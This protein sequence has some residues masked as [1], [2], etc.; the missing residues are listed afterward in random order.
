MGG[1]AGQLRD[2]GGEGE[3]CGG[4]GDVAHGGTLG[5][6]FSMDL[7]LC[8]GGWW[9]NHAPAAR[10]HPLDEALIPLFLILAKH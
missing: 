4:E 10:N 5:V 7:G 6:E 2:V 1:A 3:G 8:G 9:V